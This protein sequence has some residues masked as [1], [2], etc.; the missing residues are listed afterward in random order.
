MN[1]L[2]RSTLILYIILSFAIVCQAGV[3]ASKSFQLSVTIPPHVSTAVD[4]IALINEP[5]LSSVEESAAK[6]ETNQV[7]HNN[8]PV[9][10]QSVV[11]R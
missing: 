7:V 3:S 1:Q 6:I 2:I 4:E 9:V 10:M 11:V 5:L 8:Q